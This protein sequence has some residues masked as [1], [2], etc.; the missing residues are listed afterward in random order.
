MV[1]GSDC[2]ERGII[3]VEV[4]DGMVICSGCGVYFDQ[5][6]ATCGG[7]LVWLS[8]AQEIFHVGTCSTLQRNT[9]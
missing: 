6:N 3:W 4:L 2:G 8:Q 7:Q 1:I 5:L 9:A